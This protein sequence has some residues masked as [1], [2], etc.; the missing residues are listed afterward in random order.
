MNLY[1]WSTTASDNDSAVPDGAPEGWLGQDVNDW[2]RESMARIREQAS[3]AAYIEENYNLSPVGAKTLARVSTTQFTI[4][5]CN[6]T[7]VFTTG[8][9]IRIV[10]A[11][12]DYGYVT[13]SSYGGANTTVNVTMDSGDVPTTPTLAYVHVDTKIR[14]A[15]YY[16]TGSGNGLDADKVDGYHLADILGPAI[17][18]EAVINGGMA[19]AQRGTAISCP[20]STKT[21]TADRWFCNPAAGTLTWF[22]VSTALTGAVSKY[23]SRLLGATSV[24]STAD[25]GQR[26]ESYLIPYIKTTI[27]IS[28]LVKNE[29]GASLTLTLRLGTPGSAD[30]FTSVTNQLST[31]LTAIASAGTTRLTATV[32]IS[33]YTNIDNGLEV[34]FRVPA[35]A[36]NSA[37]KSI[38][39]TEVQIDRAANFSYFR[40]R[41][42]PDEIARCQ[43][44]YQKTFAYETLPEQ[45]WYGTFT[46]APPGA[47]IMPGS[48]HSPGPNTGVSWMFPVPMRATPTVVTF[49]PDAAAATG[50]QMDGT[51]EYTITSVPSTAGVNFY[52]NTTSLGGQDQAIIFGATAVSE[53]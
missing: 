51:G 42:I 10:G 45:G 9:R 4:A 30:D 24:T 43:R 52:A 21:L 25:F 3:D 13:S 12:T 36:L 11:T 19:V 37:V 5:G 22:Q 8:R 31:S 34:V 35:G 53:L 1:K 47:L 46:G 18:A 33:G 39:I 41:Q 49:N 38:T 40:L 26:I 50:M 27:T 14:N 2:G 48:S 32:D 20:A 28:A 29:T 23:G 17:F 15:A 6:A 16:S 7:S 44:Y